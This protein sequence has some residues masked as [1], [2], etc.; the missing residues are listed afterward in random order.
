MDASIITSIIAGLTS[1][2]LSILAAKVTAKQEIR[3]WKREDALRKD[4]AFAA[5]ASAVSQ[6][7]AQS[8][9]SIKK[10]KALKAVAEAMAVSEGASLELLR[11]LSCELS[12]EYSN[13]QIVRS[14][15]TNL[16]K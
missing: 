7:L 4:A 2:A 14:L 1:V 15:M 8:Y 12:K 9:N 16:R 6:W 3:R 13:E 11:N 10:D 5:V